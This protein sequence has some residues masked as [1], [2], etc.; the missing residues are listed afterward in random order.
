MSKPA[1][2]RRIGV[3]YSV[4]GGVAVV[5]ELPV[6]YAGS[7]GQ[8]RRQ[9]CLDELGY[10]SQALAILP[11]EPT[12]EK[13]QAEKAAQ[14]LESY[15]KD[16]GNSL[17]FSGL[18]V[19]TSYLENVSTI[20]NPKDSFGKPSFT[21]ADLKII[22][23]SRKMAGTA[24][25]HC[26]LMPFVVDAKKICLFGYA[27]DSLPN[28]T[29]PA[30]TPNSPPH[31]PTATW[32]RPPRPAPVSYSHRPDDSSRPLPISSTRHRSTSAISAALNAATS[33]ASAP[34]PF[35]SS[36]WIRP[37]NAACATANRVPSLAT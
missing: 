13:Y 17:K 24:K 16:G 21:A 14:A 26:A 15:S 12:E 23:Q 5:H 7:I 28:P 8:T 2:F 6:V 27:R 34:P 22:L 19:G 32:R 18:K 4:E 3:N 29:K 31:M 36:C 1:A 25:Q 30:A 37:M 10:G 11:T 35:P 20:R 9:K 33:A